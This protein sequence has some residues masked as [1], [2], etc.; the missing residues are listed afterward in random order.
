MCFEHGRELGVGK[1]DGV[2]C[3]AELSGG[4][5][6]RLSG[7]KLDPASGKRPPSVRNPVSF[8]SKYDARRRRQPV[9]LA[10]P[11]RQRRHRQKKPYSQAGVPAG[12]T[13]VVL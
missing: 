7:G 10:R 3:C 4:K 1:P 5:T 8:S 2:R 11:R 13:E 12:A 9:F 6:W